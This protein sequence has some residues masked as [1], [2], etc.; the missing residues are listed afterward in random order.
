M[1][2]GN[3]RYLFP[4]YADGQYPKMYASKKKM[5]CGHIGLITPLPTS[6]SKIIEKI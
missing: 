6:P 4:Q 5:A 1:P 2:A 3:L